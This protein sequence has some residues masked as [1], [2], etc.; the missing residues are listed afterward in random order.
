MREIESTTSAA[1]PVRPVVACSLAAVPVLAAAGLVVGL[2]VANVGAE[3]GENWWI[4]AWLVV[5]LVDT[6]AG[7]ALL[8]RRGHRRLASCL[9]VVGLSMLT[10]AVARQAGGYAASTEGATRWADLARAA[11]WADPLATGV[12]AALVPWE[13]AA[14]GRRLRIEAVW[15]ATAAIVV[16]TAVGEATGMAGSGVD[17]I[18]VPTWLVAASATAATLRL[19]WLW[20]RQRSTSDDLLPGW[21]AAGA[22]T[23]W[24]AVVPRSLGI[25]GSDRLS[26]DVAGPLLLM[27]TF[28]L[29]IVGAVV[30]A[31]REQPSRYHGVSHLVIGWLVLCGAIVVVYTGVVAGLGELVGGSGPTWLLAA[32]T[33]IIA[34]T[35]EPARRRIRSAVDRLVYGARDDPLEV[36]RGVVDHVGADSGDE[37]LPA[38]VTSLQHELRLDAVAIDVRTPDGWRREASHGGTT[39]FQ[40][41]VVLTH[42]NEVVGRLVVGWEHGPSLRPRDTRVLNELAG[43]LSLAV[44]WI[45]LAADLR[46]SSLAIVSA[47]EEERRRL[48]RDLHDGLGPALT[49]VSLGLRTTMRQLERAAGG[50]AVPP[51]HRLLA[52]AA[53]EVDALVGEVKRIVRDLRPTALD[54]L[55]LT[56]AVAEFARTFGEDLEIHVSM[57]SEPLD[58]PAAVEVAT[59]RIV[60]E[61]VTNVVRHA[62]AAQCWLTISAGSTVDID[63]V[64]DGI[65]LDADVA[66]GVGWAAMRERA[67]ELGGS[68]QVT[69]RAPHGTRVHVRLPAA[70]P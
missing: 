3:P 24:I 6:V 33:G 59:Y 54:Q 1:T 27:A 18:D 7:A 32:T 20:W 58:L 23:A 51:S 47:R 66:G 69:A 50:A 62:R 26:P 12:L 63:V 56:D 67:A 39:S 14:T 53:D 9:V 19:V 17:I 35:V 65:G 30:S 8:T 57:P 25:L 70:L 55:G 61:A 2:R 38:L 44:G 5:G 15:W 34:V 13:L 49:G 40:R 16:A 31:M 41:T 42:R 11:S 21:V 68:V 52:R 43:P 28:P 60:T 37:L 22:V 64:D 48:R 36:V 46:R 4:V 10:I 45:R 29:L